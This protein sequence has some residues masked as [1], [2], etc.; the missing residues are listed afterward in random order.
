MLGSSGIVGKRG[1]SRVVLDCE[2]THSFEASLTI[3]HSLAAVIHHPSPFLTLQGRRA[4]CPCSLHRN[5]SS[6][7]SAD[8]RMW[9]NKQTAE[10]EPRISL[11]RR[12]SVRRVTLQDV[13]NRLRNPRLFMLVCLCRIT[14]FSGKTMHLNGD[15]CT[16]A[17][18]I[19]QQALLI[20]FKP[21]VSR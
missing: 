1:F 14:V 18:C 20:S 3:T 17:A 10:S 15:I 8:N 4:G 21:S 2:S 5:T 6:F 11:I 9:K 7:P 16:F 12:S 19:Q 13:L